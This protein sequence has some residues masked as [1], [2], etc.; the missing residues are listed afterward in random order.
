MFLA[1]KLARRN[2]GLS[3]SESVWS[4]GQCCV[5]ETFVYLDLAGNTSDKNSSLIRNSAKRACHQ[6]LK[7]NWLIPFLSYGDCS[8]VPKMMS[9]CQ[10]LPFF[11]EDLVCILCVSHLAVR[12]IYLVLGVFQFRPLILNL[13]AACVA[14]DKESGYYCFWEFEFFLRD[15]NNVVRIDPGLQESLAQDSSTL[16][17]SF[18]LTSTLNIH[19]NCCRRTTITTLYAK[20]PEVLFDV[21]MMSANNFLE[22]FAKIWI[23]RCTEAKSQR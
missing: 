18:Q 9:K 1:L 12:R 6:I 3:R 23:D 20:A 17:K 4:F 2:C 11:C 13:S 14:V 8:D 15:K 7:A 21:R 22:G 5:S 16:A 19:R 10:S